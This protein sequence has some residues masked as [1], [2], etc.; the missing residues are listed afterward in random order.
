MLSFKNC[1]IGPIIWLSQ[2]LANHSKL[3]Q[4]PTPA[5]VATKIGPTGE[6]RR[7]VAPNAS[8]TGIIGSIYPFI[9]FQAVIILFLYSSNKFTALFH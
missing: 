4:S 9:S 5:A 3:Y 1:I 2:F 8:I 6:K 7:I